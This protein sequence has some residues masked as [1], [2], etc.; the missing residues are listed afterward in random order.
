MGGLVVRQ[1]SSLALP[2]YL[3]S[4]ASEDE[5][6]ATYLTFVDQTLPRPTGRAG[7]APQTPN[8]RREL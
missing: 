1:V 7:S 3:A 6:F 5:M 8:V 4:S 2:P